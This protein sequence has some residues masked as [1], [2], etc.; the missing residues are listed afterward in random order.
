MLIPA[1]VVKPGITVAVISLS[2]D[3]IRAFITLIVLTPCPEFSRRILRQIMCK[4]LP[5]QAQLKTMFSY[6]CPMLAHCSQMSKKSGKKASAHIITLRLGIPDA[7]TF[8]FLTFHLIL[9][10]FSLIPGISF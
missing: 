8:S 4:S 1:L 2:F 5:V 10:L 3:K 7:Y 6:K 9:Y